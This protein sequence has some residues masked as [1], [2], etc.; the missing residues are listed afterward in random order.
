MLLQI[1]SQNP[2][3]GGL[4]SHKSAVG[5]ESSVL[6]GG[7]QGWEVK[8]FVQHPRKT[9]ERKKGRRPPWPRHRAAQP[10]S[11]FEAQAQ[12]RA[13]HVCELSARQTGPGHLLGGRSCKLSRNSL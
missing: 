6:G 4:Q 10:R 7:K 9:S 8:R 1:F 11:C 3:A 2:N 13:G 5:R 12:Q